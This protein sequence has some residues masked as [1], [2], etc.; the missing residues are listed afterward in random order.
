MGNKTAG[1]IQV[2]LGLLLVL[3]GWVTS[4][5]SMWGAVILGILVLAVGLW[6]AMG[7]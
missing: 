5:R 3:S 6:E 1:W 7:K 4:L 2:V